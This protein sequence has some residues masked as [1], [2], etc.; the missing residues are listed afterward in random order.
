MG[1]LDDAASGLL[2]AAAQGRRRRRSR[3]GVPRPFVRIVDTPWPK[4]A[5]AGIG[6]LVATAVALLVAL[7]SVIVRAMSDDTLGLGLMLIFGPVVLAGA[8]AVLPIV[9]GLVN[10]AVRAWSMNG[11]T[12]IELGLVALAAIMV[13]AFPYLE[14][15][16]WP[17]LLPLLAAVGV[18]AI[19]IWPAPW[20]E[21]PTIP[22][23][24]S[25]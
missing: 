10:L 13:L 24:Y 19:S 18:L 9:G 22:L 8:F 17:L 4:V 20:R 1:L 12:R 11:N 23:L 7:G 5:A 21:P 15:W 2:G 3:V 14:S 25:E 6:V 16:W